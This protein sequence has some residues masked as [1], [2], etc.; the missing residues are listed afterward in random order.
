MWEGIEKGEYN[1]F[2]VR[3]LSDYEFKRKRGINVD[4]KS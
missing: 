3:A 4:I 1:D 2:E